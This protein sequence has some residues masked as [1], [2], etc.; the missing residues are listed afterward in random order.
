MTNIWSREELIVAFNLYCKIPF[1]RIHKNNNDI[2]KLSSVIGRSPSAVALKLTNY[3]RLDPAL[4]ERNISGMSHGSKAEAD[5][6]DEFG[7]NGEEL[8]YQ[9]ELILAGLKNTTIEDSA[10]ITTEDLPEEGKE[11]EAAVKVRVNQYF[12]R[13][14]VLAS[15]D[16][17][18]C[19][20]GISLPQLLV[21]SHIVPWAIDEKNR[22]NPCNGLCLNALHDVAFDKGLIT[23]TPDLKI[24]ISNMVQA[25]Q[26]AG[27]YF[28]RYDG[29]P[30][31]LPRKYIPSQEFLEYHNSNI[32]QN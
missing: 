11:R 24:K 17:R 22:M 32:F 26:S 7:H 15:Y 6:W 31:I 18:C 13:K 9:S 30:I 1:G 28:S 23:V 5:I 8:A 25:N 21:A 4:R 2:V 12:F 29:K 20:T 27:A 3:A 14:M 19:I 10:N 16:F